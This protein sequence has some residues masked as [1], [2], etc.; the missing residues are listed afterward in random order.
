ML[1]MSEAM[2]RGDVISRKDQIRLIVMLSIPAIFE[3]LV[4]TMMNYIDTARGYTV[5]EQFLGEAMEGMRDK[6][7]IATKSMAR[8]KEAMAK[9]LGTGLRGK[10]TLKSL[11]IENDELGAPRAVLDEAARDALEKLGAAKMLV[12]VSH[13]K[14]YAIAFAV[15]SR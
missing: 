3:Q 14:E 11:S 13:L 8:T 6:F 4:M 10:I 1:Q 7:V 2:R 15:A 9:A 5:S 12:S